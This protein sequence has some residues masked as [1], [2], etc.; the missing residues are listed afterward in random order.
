MT[1]LMFVPRAS[2]PG[3]DGQYLRPLSTYSSPSRSAITPMPAGLG[4]GTSKFAV[5]PGVPA[6]SLA[7]HPPRYSPEGSDVAALRNRSFC[8]SEPYH[9]TGMSPSPLHST[10]HAKPGSTAQI[11][12]AA[13]L[14]STLDRPPPPYSSGIMHIAMPL[15]YPST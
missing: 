9:T 2:H 5:P 14:M 3:L 6:G 7:V 10:V 13:R 11:S 8:S 12:S 15:L 1:V 4:K